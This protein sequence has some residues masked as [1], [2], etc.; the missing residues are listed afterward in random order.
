MLLVCAAELVLDLRR[1]QPGPRRSKCRRKPLLKG[2]AGE[3]ADDAINLGAAPGAQA[4]VSDD[5]C[6]RRPQDQ[7]VVDSRRPTF[8]AMRW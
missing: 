2:G 5:L 8:L 7:E 6:E 4:A 1:R 3:G